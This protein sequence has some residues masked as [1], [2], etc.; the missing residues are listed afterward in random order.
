MD[1]LQSPSAF[2]LSYLKNTVFR[3]FRETTE[4]EIQNLNWNFL[5]FCLK[6]L[7]NLYKGRRYSKPPGNPCTGDWAPTTI[8]CSLS[9]PYCS[10]LFEM[11]TEGWAAFK[12]SPAQPHVIGHL[13]ISQ[14]RTCL[15][16]LPLLILLCLFWP[17]SSRCNTSGY[18]S[19]SGP[20]QTWG[21]SSPTPPQR[22]T[23]CLL[24][25]VGLSS[26]R[27]HSQRPLPMTFKVVLSALLCPL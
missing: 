17:P 14:T 22:Y 12:S 21:F 6:K 3:K 9:F 4:G 19:A 18:T 25:C 26:H 23:T 13:G 2:W 11:G 15:L 16:K 10:S 5:K 7:L 1:K 8:N 24:L 20:S 27:P